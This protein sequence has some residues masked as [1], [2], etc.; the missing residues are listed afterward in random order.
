MSMNSLAL[1]YQAAGKLD[2]ALPLLEETLKLRKAKIGADHPNTINS[3]NNLAGAYQAAGRLDLALPLLQETFKMAREKLGPNHPLTLTSMNNLARAYQA[4][5]KLDLALPL[6]EETYRLRKAEL[7]ADHPSTI[8]SLG[9][10][11]RAYQAGG[12]LDLALP[13]LETTHKLMEAKLGVDHP[14]TLISMTALALGYRAAGKLKQSLPLLQEAAAGMEKK[15]FEHENAG[16]IVNGLIGCYE[17]LKQLDHAEAW[18]R[19]WLAVVKERA[20]ADSPAYSAELAGLGLNL[21][22]QKKWTDA[23]AA[24]RE[25]LAIRQKKEPDAWTTFNTQSMLGQALLGQKKYADA[26]PLLVHGYEGMQ[27]RVAKMPPQSKARLTE[28]LDRLVQLYEATGK[29]TEADQWRKKLSDT[30]A[31]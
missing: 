27:Q 26:E 23:E 17:E 1:G 21:I 16:G 19:K 4:E 12:K 18:R 6:F 30:P 29:K 28:A 10:L 24:L 8:I 25:S 5:G 13:L 31:K 9:N 20:G 22:Q 2:L 15:H 7:G 3:M 11:G 14:N